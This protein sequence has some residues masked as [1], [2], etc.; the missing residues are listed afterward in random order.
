MFCFVFNYVIIGLPAVCLSGTKRSTAEFDFC[1]YFHQKPAMVP[2]GNPL[3][4]Y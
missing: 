1:G 2:L 4:K 3:F